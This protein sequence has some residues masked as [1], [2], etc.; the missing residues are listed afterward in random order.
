MPA[1]WSVEEFRS[2]LTSVAD[3]TVQ[4]YIADVERFAAWAGDRAGL[5]GP[6]A[7]TRLLLRRYLAYLTTLGRRK[8]SIARTAAALR[9][10][11]AWLKRTGRVATDP[12]VRL[13]AP[14]G[15]ARLPHVLTRTEVGDLLDEPPA[16]I[17][18][19]E[20][21]VR[22][23][24]DAVL[25]LLYGS[26]LRVAELC[27]LAEADIDVGRGLLTVIGKGSKQRQVPLSE[28]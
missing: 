24:D 23:R 16:R 20:P 12:A 9:R 10:Y 25:E 3:A 28:P 27:G 14:A 2:S 18:Q 26:G 5:A 15:E 22:L 11:F 21:C 17:D 13:S 4:A 8:R 19:D 1:P 6:H 7:V